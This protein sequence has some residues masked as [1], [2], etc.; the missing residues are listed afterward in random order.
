MVKHYNLC[1]LILLREEEKMCW[2]SPTSIAWTMRSKSNQRTT[3]KILGLWPGSPK[4]LSNGNTNLTHMVIILVKH[5]EK[6][7]LLVV[8]DPRLQM[9]CEKCFVASF[10]PRILI[11]QLFIWVRIMF[12]CSWK[13]HHSTI[14]FNTK[15][16]KSEFGN[17]LLEPNCW[18]KYGLISC[19]VDDYM[20]LW[21][22]CLGIFPQAPNL[23]D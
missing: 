21:R 1:N 6:C 10:A 15:L 20:E 7:H 13:N 5:H 17:T 19:Q 9:L 16:K 11:T 8:D 22:A 14:I 18:V 3:S 12:N 2:W 23:V 4:L